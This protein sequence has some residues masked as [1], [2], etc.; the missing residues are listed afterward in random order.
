MTQEDNEDKRVTREDNE[1]AFD[2]VY[3]TDILGDADDGVADC[4]S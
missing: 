4:E 2:E 3:M 1:E